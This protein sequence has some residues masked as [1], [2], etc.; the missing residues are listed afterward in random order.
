M[1]RS[2]NTGVR[3]CGCIVEA[4]SL[5]HTALPL[6][7]GDVQVVEAAFFGPAIVFEPFQLAQQGFVTLTDEFIAAGNGAVFVDGHG[8]HRGMAHAFAPAR[9]RSFQPDGTGDQTVR[10]LVGQVIEDLVLGMLRFRGNRVQN[11][12]DE[13][14]MAEGRG[15]L[16]ARTDLFPRTFKRRARR[17]RTALMQFRHVTEHGSPSRFA[18]AAGF[19]FQCIQQEDLP[20][21][22]QAFS[23]NVMSS[24]IPAT[25]SF[26]MVS[27]SSAP[28]CDGSPKTPILTA[29]FCLMRGMTIG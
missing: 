28:A 15:G 6:P 1:R 5:I 26:V 4:D 14:P 19:G 11:L 3:G 2:V 13:I 10:L 25:T 24:T 17:M 21:S 22:S 8:P 27:P 7:V 18:Q 16:V 23:I 9:F 20:F 12:V 29:S